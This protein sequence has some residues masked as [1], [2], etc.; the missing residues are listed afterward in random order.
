MEISGGAK[1]TFDALYLEGNRDND[2]I[3]RD[4]ETS[5]VGLDVLFLHKNEGTTTNSLV[6]AKSTC[7]NTTTVDI[8]SAK[9]IVSNGESGNNN[10][11]SY[12]Y[13]GEAPANVRIN[14]IN[15]K[16][17]GTLWAAFAGRYAPVELS[18]TTPPGVRLIGNR[19]S[20]THIALMESYSG[21]AAPASSLFSL[22]NYDGSVINTLSTGSRVV[23]NTFSNGVDYWV[24]DGAAFVAIN[25]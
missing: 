24:W 11:L 10:N 22:A 9:V 3:I 17:A 12:M 23:S 25:R 19:N 1:V 14:N 2:I 15:W 21:I 18:F 7:N 5:L 4:P 16:G 20:P 13:V 8:R 6:N